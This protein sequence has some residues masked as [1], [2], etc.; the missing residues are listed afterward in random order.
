M[1]FPVEDKSTGEKVFV[2]ND[3]RSIG[4]SEHQKPELQFDIKTA[5]WYAYDENYGTSEEK[6][7]VKYFASQINKLKEKYQDSEI[8][9]IRNELDYWLY[10]PQ[11]G[12]RFSPDYILIVNDV[13]NNQVY[14]QC[15]IEPKGGHLLEQDEW[16]EEALISINDGSKVVF[17]T[18]EGDK[19][20]YREY[21]KEAERLGYKEIRPLGLK[22]YNSDTRGEED[23]AIDLQDKLL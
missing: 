8:Y 5:E 14:Y 16:K 18:D 4:Q 20:G 7:F 15:L 21:L 12:R 13:N 17:D 11:D 6:K 19:L 1:S 23:F 22:F 9:L 3:E 2:S 10:S